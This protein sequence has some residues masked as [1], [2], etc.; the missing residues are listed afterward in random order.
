MAENFHIVVEGEEDRRFLKSYLSTLGVTIPDG[1]LRALN[2]WT[3]LD[4]YKPN[5]EQK[6]DQGVKVII[7]FDANNSQEKRM[8]QI[9]DVLGNITPPVFLF[10]DDK[11][12][13]GL[14]DLLLQIV[15]PEY[16]EV[17]ECFDDYK[18]CLNKHNHNY[19]LP[20]IK[21]KVYAYKE[22]IGALQKRAD[23]FDSKY[24]NYGHPALNPL[25]KFLTEHIGK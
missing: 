12:A 23:Q 24:W 1:H 18:K 8:K 7:I 22:A 15:I 3:N 11:S 13:G 21:G 10:P 9:R 4:G 25:K 20:D 5:I 14:E 2:G 6:Q 17:L 19:T 16:L